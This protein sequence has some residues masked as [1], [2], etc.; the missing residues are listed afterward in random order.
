MKTEQWIWEENS[1]WQNLTQTQ[2]SSADLVLFFGGRDALSE[3]SRFEE[4]R[5]KFPEAIVIGCSTAGEILGEEV[6]D[7]SVVLTAIDFEKTELK[8]A[9][10]DMTETDIPAMQAGMRLGKELASPDLKAVFIL[11]DGQMVNGSELVEG[12]T[13]ALGEKVVLTGGLAGDGGRFEKT[14]VS[15]NNAPKPGQIAVIGF[16]GDAFKIG[17]GSVGGW[18]PFGPVRTVTKSEGNVLF[19]LDDHPALELYKQY[20]GE[21]ANQLPGSA[22]LFPLQINHSEQSGHGTVRTVLNIDENSQSMTFAGDIPEGYQA[23]LM[24][25]NFENLIEG[26]SQAANH[27]AISDFAQSENESFAILISCVGRKMVLGQRTEDEVEA[28]QEV[29][30]ENTRQ[31]GFYSYGEISP[32]V[33]LGNCQLHNQ[34]MT[35]TVFQEIR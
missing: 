32:H 33:T 31:L 21:D 1:Q 8:L 6:F 23:Q 18:D 5:E 14:L 28:V 26:A 15:A 3:S 25:A 17:H 2:L 16:Y 24:M 13:L 10:L 12:L 11:S 7:D 20:L 34:T 19:Q 9:S 30:G 4:I 35:I 22:L 27:A 29:L